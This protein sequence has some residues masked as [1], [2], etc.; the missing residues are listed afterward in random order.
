MSWYSDLYGP[1]NPP[2]SIDPASQE[3]LKIADVW[4]MRI[5][6][7]ALAHPNL[8]IP[9][10]NEAENLGISF[11]LNMMEHFMKEKILPVHDKQYEVLRVTEW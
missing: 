4:L 9:Y 7:Y 6:A 8:V 11:N 10:C 5:S 3:D 1:R 2:R